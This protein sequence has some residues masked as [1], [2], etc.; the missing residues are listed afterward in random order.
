MIAVTFWELKN[1]G[2][3][4]VLCN[5]RPE[6]GADL[7]IVQEMLGQANIVTTEIYAHVNREDF[8]EVHW[9]FRLRYKQ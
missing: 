9:S 5:Q 8:K 7:R 6:G 3:W 1:L 2:F 4:W